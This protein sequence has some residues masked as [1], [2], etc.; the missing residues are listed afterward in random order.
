MPTP[1]TERGLLKRRRRRLNAE[2]ETSNKRFRQA[3]GD[4]AEEYVCPTLPSFPSTQ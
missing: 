3:I 2:T 4:V 1:S